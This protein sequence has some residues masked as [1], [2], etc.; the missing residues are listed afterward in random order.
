[1]DRLAQRFGSLV[2]DGMMDGSIRP[3]DPAIAACLI[4]TMINAAGI[5]RR[6]PGERNA[7]AQPSDGPE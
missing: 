4:D 6:V 1:M 7:S 5:E 3:L 2:V